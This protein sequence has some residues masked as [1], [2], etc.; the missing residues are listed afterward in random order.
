MKKAQGLPFSV[1]VIAII[2]LIV[3]V[4]VSLIFVKY[5]RDSSSEFSSCSLKGGTCE[6][7]CTDTQ[8]KFDNTDCSQ[9]TDNKKLCCVQV[10]ND[11]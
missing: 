11:S 3:A 8:A 7:K 4:V 6:D 2:V 5:V 1:I 10:L 9:R